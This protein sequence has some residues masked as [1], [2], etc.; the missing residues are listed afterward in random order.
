LDST[1]KVISLIWLVLLAFLGLAAA[2]FTNRVLKVLGQGPEYLGPVGRNALRILGVSVLA[3]ALYFL[4]SGNFPH[5][6]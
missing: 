2:L 1:P 3:A 4:L 5:V 6:R